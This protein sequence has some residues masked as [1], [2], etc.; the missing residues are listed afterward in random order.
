MASDQAKLEF[1]DW[2]I[3][4]LTNSNFV[5]IYHAIFWQIDFL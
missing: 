3:V 1:S 2:I 4:G 5:N